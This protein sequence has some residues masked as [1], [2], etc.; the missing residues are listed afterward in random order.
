MRENLK[1]EE[2]TLWRD[3]TGGCNEHQ[4][5]GKRHLYLVDFMGY[6]DRFLE[7]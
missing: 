6:E 7:Y 4:P 3:G 1:S 5:S 2:G